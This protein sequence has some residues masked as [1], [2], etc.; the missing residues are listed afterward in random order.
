MA[1]PAA[2]TGQAWR[3]QAA[4]AVEDGDADQL[5]LL[6]T[7]PVYARHATPTVRRDARPRV[8]AAARCGGLRF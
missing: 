4:E 3:Q 6:L 8:A 7:L 1:S 5:R 2:V